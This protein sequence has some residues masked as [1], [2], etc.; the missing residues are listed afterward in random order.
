M[1]VLVVTHGE[2]MGPGWLEDALAEVGAEHETIDPSRGDPVPSDHWDKVIVLGGHMGAYDVED[3]PWLE[4]EKDFIKQKITGGTPLLGVCLGAQQ[5]ADVIGGRAFRSD[6]TEAG[7]WT[8]QPTGAGRDDAVMSTIAGPVVA[9]HQD[10]FELPPDAELL[11]ATNDYPH[12]FRYG[13][14]L[15]VQFHPEVTPEMF[16][17]WASLAKPEELAEA[18][19]D[20]ESFVRDLDADS[21]RLRRQAVAFFRTWLEE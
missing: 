8:C 6:F 21:E 2:E 5:I 10:T 16:R 1:R 9:W 3:H 14:A 4:A 20:P 15:G 19:L 18:G 17:T 13:P 7:R 12:A 11:G